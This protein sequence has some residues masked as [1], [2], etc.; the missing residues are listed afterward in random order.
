MW[1]FL[2]RLM[3]RNRPAI[4]VV[5]GLLTV[6]MGWQGLNVK[7]SYN[8]MSMLP[9]SDSSVIVYNKF[10]EKFGEDGSVLVIGLTNKNMFRLDQINAW[11]DLTNEIS[12]IDGVEGVTSITRAANMVKNDSLRQFQFKPLMSGK[13]DTQAQ[14]DSL[15]KLVFSLPFYQGLLFNPDTETYLMAVTLNKD[16]LND[17]ARLTVTDN[18][19]EAA[20]AFAEKTGNELHY[21]GMPYIRSVMTKKQN[22]SS[23]YSY[24]CQLSLLP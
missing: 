5:I 2:V 1:N 14:A 23:S 13:L 18:I 20:Q 4:L 11:Y 7:L 16:K 22:P 12:R 8:N 15:R 19:V 21:S 17:K 3:L 10:K 6:F 24:S 9:A